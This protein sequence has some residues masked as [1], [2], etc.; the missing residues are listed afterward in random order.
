VKSANYGTYTGEKLRANPLPSIH[1]DSEI[2]SV[3]VNRQNIK[4]DRIIIKGSEYT[5]V[6]LTPGLTYIISVNY[7]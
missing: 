5:S 1:G 7:F 2:S 4:F 6:T 3:T